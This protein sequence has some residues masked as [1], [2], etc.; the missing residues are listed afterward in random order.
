MRQ[1]PHV[2]Q[3]NCKAVLSLGQASP[4]HIILINSTNGFFFIISLKVSSCSNPSI[5]P[6][7][8]FFYSLASSSLSLS[9]A[10]TSTKS[11]FLICPSSSIFNPPSSLAQSHCLCLQFSL[12]FPPPSLFMYIYFLPQYY[13]PLNLCL[14]HILSLYLNL[15]SFFSV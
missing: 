14:V 11:F 2:H 4:Y 12:T 15:F 7:I 3:P 8:V 9:A 1:K 6:T 5:N 10:F 13:S